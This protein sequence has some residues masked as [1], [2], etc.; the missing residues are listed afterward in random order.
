MF[1]SEGP[2]LHVREKYIDYHVIQAIEN[3]QSGSQDVPTTKPSDSEKIS[4]VEDEVDKD[5]DEKH[6]LDDLKNNS[7]NEVISIHIL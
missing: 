7:S 3:T 6:N 5:N 4:G 1:Y 2:P